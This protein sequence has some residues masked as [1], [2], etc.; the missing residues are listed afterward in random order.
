MEQPTPLCQAL[1]L[2]DR[3]QAYAMMVAAQPH[4]WSFATFESSL[5]SPYEA[6]GLYQQ[7][8]LLGF[9]IILPT[10]IAGHR[11]VTLMEIVVGPAYQR[12]GY[13]RQLLQHLLRT[14][15]QRD[16]SEIWLEVR[17]SNAPACALY[18]QM[19]FVQTQIRKQYYPDPESPNQRE[20][21]RVMCWRP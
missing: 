5:E 18:Q 7:R 11:E 12:L 20:D 16:W 3:R 2:S 6:I 14:A 19:G 9:Y 13:G 15:K 1:A 17:S 10:E 4:H 8:E 21:A